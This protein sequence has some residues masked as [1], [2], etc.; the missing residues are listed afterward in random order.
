MYQTEADL[1]LGFTEFIIEHNPQ[2]IIGYNILGFDI[3]YMIERAKFQMV[4]DSFNQQGCIKY[5][6]AQER[7]IKWSSSAYKNQEFQY[8]DAFGRLFVDL[9]PLI[10]T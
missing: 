5:R 3:P 1:L 8:L 2:L 10:K 9:L 7:L 4:I 6:H